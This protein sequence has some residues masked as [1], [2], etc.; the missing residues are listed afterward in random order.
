MKIKTMGQ[1]QRML[2]KDGHRIYYA[3]DLSSMKCSSPGC[4]HSSHDGVEMFVHQ[5]CHTGR[6]LLYNKKEEYVILFCSVCAV[7]VLS[8]AVDNTGGASYISSESPC[9]QSPWL[10]SIHDGQVTFHCA[11][12]GTEWGTM[13]IARLEENNNG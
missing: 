7:H 1:K 10:V 5:I 9:H 12:C 11:E 6:G 4:D 8:F 3:E 13:T 2:D